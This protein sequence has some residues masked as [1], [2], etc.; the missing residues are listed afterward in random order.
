M[1]TVKMVFDRLLD[2]HWKHRLGH[3]IE[4]VKSREDIFKLMEKELEITYPIMKRRTT[5]FNMTQ[6]AGVSFSDFYREVE[7]QGDESRLK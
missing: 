1:E 4:D 5:F 2:N 3:K 6:K 7:K